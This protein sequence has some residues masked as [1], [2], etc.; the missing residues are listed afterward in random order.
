MPL[1]IRP[2]VMAMLW[3][4]RYAGRV[5]ERNKE[6][7]NMYKRPNYYSTGYEFETTYAGCQIGTDRSWG[8]E[9]GLRRFNGLY[10]VNEV[11]AL[12]FT[13]VNVGL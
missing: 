2:T 4:H 1:A 10:E 8:L 9:N 12:S 13:A 5:H 11:P 7:I 3:Y 6:Y